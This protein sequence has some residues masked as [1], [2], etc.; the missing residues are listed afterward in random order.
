MV[1][2]T[3]GLGGTNDPTPN[4]PMGGKLSGDQSWRAPVAR[5][6]SGID[7]EHDEKYFTPKPAPKVTYGRRPE[8]INDLPTAPEKT[9]RVK[10]KP[11]ATY[12]SLDGFPIPADDWTELP[13]SPGLLLAIKS[14]DLEVEPS[15]KQPRSA[16]RPQAPRRP[17]PR[18][19]PLSSEATSKPPAE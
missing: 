19:Q 11:P 9:I 1:Q 18:P 2:F 13:V 12:Y 17:P 14:G 5:T 10:S 4:R 6:P 16:P 7:W 3:A 8:V 15:D